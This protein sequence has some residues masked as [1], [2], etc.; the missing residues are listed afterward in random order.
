MMTVNLSSFTLTQLLQPKMPETITKADDDLRKNQDRGYQVVSETILPFGDI[1]I[2]FIRL[3]T[4]QSSASPEAE[5][6]IG[7][8]VREHGAERANQILQQESTDRAWKAGKAREAY[9]HKIKPIALP[10]LLSED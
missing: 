4:K 1:F 8:L 2:R 9:Y 3:E 7:K 6:A 5:T 10:V